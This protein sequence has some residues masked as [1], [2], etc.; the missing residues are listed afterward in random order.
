[1]HKVNFISCEIS[2]SEFAATFDQ[3][4]IAIEEKIDLFEVNDSF[5][6]FNNDEFNDSDDLQL[7][8]ENG[9]N[10]EISKMINLAAE[11]SDSINKTPEYFPKFRFPIS[12]Y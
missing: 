8:N 3:I 9:L 7:Q 1:M 6:V 10:L 11:K 12:I 4:A 5:L 2:Q